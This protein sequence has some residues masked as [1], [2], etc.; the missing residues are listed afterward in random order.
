M[1][2]GGEEEETKNQAQAENLSQRS[3]KKGENDTPD[4]GPEENNLGDTIITIDDSHDEDEDG[5]DNGNQTNRSFKEE[6]P[7]IVHHTIRRKQL[8]FRLK[9]TTYGLMTWKTAEEVVKEH[10]RQLKDYLVGLRTK[11]PTRLFNMVKMMPELAEILKE[12]DE[13]DNQRNNKRGE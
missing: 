8:K 10:I 11:S 7:V 5:N 13:Q 1:F 3:E 6:I 4:N 12:A 2:A 9:W